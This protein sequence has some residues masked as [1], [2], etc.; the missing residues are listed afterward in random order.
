MSQQ[1]PS[2]IYT[3]VN[4][5]C[6]RCREGDMFPPGSLYSRRFADMYPSCPCCGQTYEPEPGFY[7]GAMYVS[8]GFSTAIFLAVFLLLNMLVAEVTLAMVVGMVLV[9][10]V[11]LLPL[12]YRLSRAVWINI[13]I[14][15]EGPCA[16][17]P[18]L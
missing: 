15:Y 10:A 9:I 8:F 17:I 5:K 4:G 11:G 7:Y 12:I 14:R 1:K 3:L 6:P 16:A 2:L 13:F 18:K